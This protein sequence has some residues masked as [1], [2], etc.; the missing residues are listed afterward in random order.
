MS[1]MSVHSTFL[2]TNPSFI[3][4]CFT[5]PP[6]L[7]IQFCIPLKFPTSTLSCTDIPASTSKIHSYFFPLSLSFI[8][9]IPTS[10]LLPP[11]STDIFEFRPNSHCY[12]HF[13]LHVLS[14]SL[15][16]VSTLIIL[17]SLS[18]LSQDQIYLTIPASILMTTTV[19]A[20]G[21]RLYHPPSTALRSPDIYDS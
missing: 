6:R 3:T 10:P 5:F 14:L 2:S 12:F 21:P 16:P 11:S 4:T 1:Q 7:Q 15:S 9:I 13:Q 17:S 20:T 18:F 19:Y 8:E